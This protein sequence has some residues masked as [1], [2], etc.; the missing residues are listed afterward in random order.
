MQQIVRVGIGRSRALSECSVYSHPPSRLHPSLSSSFSI[1]SQQIFRNDLSLSYSVT[2]NKSRA[3]RHCLHVGS[4][5][6]GTSTSHLPPTT[7]EEGEKDCKSRG[8]GRTAAVT[9]CLLNTMRLAHVCSQGTLS[10]ARELYEIKRVAIL[11]RMVK[12]NSAPKT[13]LLNEELLTA[14]GY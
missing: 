2:S 4:A 8:L 14:D 13:P 7:V 3:V 10:P 11:A 12:H 9:Q 6:S 5:L 1:P